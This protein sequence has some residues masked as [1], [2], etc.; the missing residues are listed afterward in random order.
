MADSSENAEPTGESLRSR[1]RHAFAV[2]DEHGDKLLDDEEELLQSIAQNIHRRGL[3]V[4][5]IPF[6]LFHK[7]LNVVGANI[8]QMGEI[9]FQTNTAENYLRKFLGKNYTHQRLVRTLEKRYSIDRL[10]ELLET[11]V[12]ESPGEESS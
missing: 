2:G 9:F 1:L 4:A 11:L 7:P 10:V 8:I 6:L 3:A 5:A 12:D